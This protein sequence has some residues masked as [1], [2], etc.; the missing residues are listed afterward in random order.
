MDTI[1]IGGGTDG[2]PLVVAILCV[3]DL[4]ED[5]WKKLDEMN[6]G[7]V[8]L[9]ADEQARR[10]INTQRYIMERVMAMKEVTMTTTIPSELDD[11]EESQWSIY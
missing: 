3:T 2:V 11:I 5:R 7:K 9:V 10:K 8:Q 1:N 4:V 6:I